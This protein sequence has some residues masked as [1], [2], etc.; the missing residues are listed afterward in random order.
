MN[1]SVVASSCCPSVNLMIQKHCRPYQTSIPM[2]C[3][4]VPEY[5]DSKSRDED[6][7]VSALSVPSHGKR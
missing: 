2:Q 6:A 7:K 3:H 4:T 1:E 5:A